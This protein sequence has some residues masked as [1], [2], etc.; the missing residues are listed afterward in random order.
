MFR[1]LH[2]TCTSYSEPLTGRQLLTMP[3]ET[4]VWLLL[5]KLQSVPWDISQSSGALREKKLDLV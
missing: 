4:W 5:L 2:V 1:A 3:A